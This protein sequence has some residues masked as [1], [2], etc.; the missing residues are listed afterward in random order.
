M[1]RRLLAA[2][3][4]LAS[5]STAHAVEYTDVN[6]AASTISFT[7]TQMG[8]QVYGTF[9]A[10]QATLSFDTHNPGA[11][12]TVLTIQLPS[13]NAGSDDANAELPKTGWFDM[14]TY[15]VG[16]F[17]STHITDLG[18]NRYLFSGNLTLKGQTRPVEVKVV[19]K[20]QRGIGVFD[21]EFVLKRA[22][23]KI[24]AGEWADSVV[25]NEIIIK[26]KMVAPQ[27]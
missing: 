27:R 6:P 14:T 19:L 7:Y 15:P 12:R 23:F 9:A 5:L 18:A 26:F 3:L 20:E 16:T 4:T 22:D 25:S 10:Y 24:G 2:L 1:K 11:A 13:I 21:G 8:Q 17:T